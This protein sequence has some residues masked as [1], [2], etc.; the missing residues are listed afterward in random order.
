MASR[1]G[2]QCPP[3]RHFFA[4]ELAIVVGV[5]AR[6]PPLRR[7]GD[8]LERQSSVAVGVQE[9]EVAR[10]SQPHEQ[11]AAAA[12]LVDRKRAVAVD[13]G[14][15][16]EPLLFGPDFSKTDF[17]VAVGIQQLHGVAGATRLSS[18][19]ALRLRHD[20]GKREGRRSGRD[21]QPCQWCR[22]S[23]GRILLD[24]SKRRLD[25]QAALPITRGWAGKSVA[26]TL[27]IST[28]RRADRPLSASVRAPRRSSH[29]S[30]GPFC[31]RASPPRHIS[32]AAGR[33]GTSSPKNRR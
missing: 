33:D 31:A 25:E 8:F 13:I 28:Q 2:V 9:I 5:V 20:G 24:H 21:Q 15:A 4:F 30:R 18:V 17:A 11:R 22:W 16:D 19:A 3:V 14:G 27:E 7:L 32:P 12:K 1:H 26:A 23:H 10:R 29:R 6:E